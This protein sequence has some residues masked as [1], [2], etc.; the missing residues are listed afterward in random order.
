MGR[1]LSD[2]RDPDATAERVFGDQMQARAP[3]RAAS[4]G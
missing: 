2:W 4:G 1:K 3:Q